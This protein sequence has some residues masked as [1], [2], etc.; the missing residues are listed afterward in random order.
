[1]KRRNHTDEFFAVFTSEAVCILLVAWLVPAMWP[2]LV[3]YLVLRACWG[4]APWAWKRL[5]NEVDLLRHYKY[6][7]HKMSRRIF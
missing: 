5:K 3:A 4:I 7:R 2:L 6:A 1:M